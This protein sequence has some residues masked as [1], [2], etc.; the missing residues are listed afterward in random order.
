LSRSSLNANLY[1]QF[2]ETIQPKSRRAL[3]NSFHKQGSK[4]LRLAHIL[5]RDNRTH[6]TNSHFKIR[7][8]QLLS[9]KIAIPLVLS[10]TAVGFATTARWSRDTAAADPSLATAEQPALI[11]VRDFLYRYVGQVSISIK[12]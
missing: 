11:P 2:N 3:T 7:I 1:K 5:Y 4:S 10:L 12:R 9:L 8:Q 6:F